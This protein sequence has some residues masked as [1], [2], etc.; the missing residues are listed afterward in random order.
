M[1]FCPTSLTADD[2]DDDFVL[3]VA[4]HEILHAL[5]SNEEM[6]FFKVVMQI[7]DI[8]RLNCPHYTI[9]PLT[10]AFH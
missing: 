3:A 1:N 6:H 7:T 5:V 2:V 4:K 9:K 10:V 8:G